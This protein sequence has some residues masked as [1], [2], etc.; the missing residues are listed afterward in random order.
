MDIRTGGT[1]MQ[2]K[3]WVKPELIDLGKGKPEENAIGGCGN[4]T[5]VS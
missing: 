5:I 2:K 3:T 4:K 1:K